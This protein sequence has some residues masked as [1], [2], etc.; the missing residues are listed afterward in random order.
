MIKLFHVFGTFGAVSQ[1]HLTWFG[2]YWKKLDKG[3][4]QEPAKEVATRNYL[5]MTLESSNVHIKDQG[6]TTYPK[7]EF[8]LL[9][10]LS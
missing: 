1:K 8:S 3:Q 7:R 4:K 5:K 2:S 10:K 6:P 9:I